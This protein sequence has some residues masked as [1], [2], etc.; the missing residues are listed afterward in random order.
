MKA[1]TGKLF[2]IYCAAAILIASVIRFFQYVTIMDFGTGFFTY[3]NGG[4]GA[5]IY[6]VLFT[7]ALGFIALTVFGVKKKWTATT[8]SSDGMDS[9]STIIPGIAFLLSA[10]LK[11][12]ETIGLDGMGFFRL[13]SGYTCA[14]ALAALG[15][16][17][18]KSSKPPFVSGVVILVLSLYLFGCA[19][20]LFTSDLIVKNRS[21]NLILLLIYVAATLFFV[22]SARFYSRLETK[23]SRPREIITGGITF[24]LSG[25]HIVSKLFAYAFGGD[26]ILRMDSISF[27][28]VIIFLVSGAFL[29]TIST[30]T[31]SA[32]ID[33][34]LPEKEEDD[35]AEEKTDT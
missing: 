15:L 4:A 26:A 24:I 25:V 27:D 32:E 11:V 21:D 12:I 19:V 34:I 23:L 28:A 14:L 33:Y 16:I 18:L 10:A 7:A 13:L 5:L 35:E 2:I 9:K 6:A 20:S 31:Q 8:V 30:T 22:A 1:K 29:V 3:G 17:L